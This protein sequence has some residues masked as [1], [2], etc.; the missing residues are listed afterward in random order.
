MPSPRAMQK[1]HARSPSRSNARPGG[2]RTGGHLVGLSERRAHG[3]EG[4]PHV[5][6]HRR[7]SIGCAAPARAASVPVRWAGALVPVADAVG[8]RHLLSAIRATGRLRQHVLLSRR[9]TPGRSLIG[10]RKG[11]TGGSACHRIERRR[12]A[13]PHRVRDDR[14]GGVRCPASPDASDR[15]ARLGAR[16]ASNDARSGTT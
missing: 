3:P 10:C 12:R 15:I 6:R 16:A 2:C 5:T 9:R 7:C 13:V 8:L 14:S 4:E 1:R 11:S